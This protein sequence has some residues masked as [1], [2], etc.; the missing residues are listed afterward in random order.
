M[1]GFKERAIGLGLVAALFLGSTGCDF[2]QQHLNPPPDLTAGAKQLADGDLPAAADEWDKLATAHPDSVDVA[3]GKA[4]TQLLSGDYKGADATLA[5]VEPTAKDKLGELE[6]RR[7]LVALRDGRLDDVKKHGK[8]SGLPEGKLLAAEVHLVD[9]ESDEGAALFRE[10]SASDGAVGETA[11][12]YL[13]MLESDDQHLA[14]LAEAT[15]LW[16]LGDRGQSVQSA[17]EL[18]REL[19]A[20]YEKK[21][22]LLMIWASRAATSGKP[23]IANSL[24]DDLEFPPEGQAW[25]VEA[26]RAIAAVAAGQPE[27]ASQKFNALRTAGAPADGLADALA[28]ACGVATDPTIA[29]KLAEG[30]E[31]AAAARCLAKAG[32]GD[33]ASK[34]PDGP[35][36]SFLENP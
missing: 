15:A 9:L 10:L 19:P 32:E 8:D 36:K 12:T 23:A 31:S 25:R 22:E 5:A 16:A 24:L 18:V 21:N 4:Y 34:A 29:K 30:V 33:A 35:L 2:I 27:V 3:V 26:I 7:A 13:S 11:K 17:E 20:D 1:P 28:T 6:L 14:G